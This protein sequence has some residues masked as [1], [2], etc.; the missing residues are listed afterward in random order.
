MKILRRDEEPDESLNYGLLT[1]SGITLDSS[2]E[3]IE[4]ISPEGDMK[5]AAHNLFAALHRLDDLNLDIIYA[6]EFPEEGLGCAIMDRLR[7]AAAKRS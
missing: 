1:H 6:Y 4:R 5:E 2:C 3:H 7:K